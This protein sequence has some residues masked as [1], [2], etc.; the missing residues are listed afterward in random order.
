MMDG[1][2]AGYTVTQSWLGGWGGS[3]TVWRIWGTFYFLV[4]LS[5]PADWQDFHTVGT[6]TAVRLYLLPSSGGLWLGGDPENRFQLLRPIHPP[7][8][9]PLTSGDRGRFIALGLT[10]Q[11]KLLNL[12]VCICTHTGKTSHTLETRTSLQPGIKLAT[13]TS[14]SNH[15]TYWTPS[16]QHKLLQEQLS[17]WAG[18]P[19]PSRDTCL[20]K[21]AALS[22]SSQNHLELTK[23]L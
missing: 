10:D 4:F 1:W 3:P 15:S 22:S 23:K 12:L 2:T 14:Q 21:G 20:K 9:W 7:E 17:Y 13:L 11:S 8:S 19:S 18:K 16:W 6:N 5:N